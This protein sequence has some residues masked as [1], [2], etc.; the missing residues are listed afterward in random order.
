MK[1]GLYSAAVERALR[2]ALDAHDGQVRKGLDPVPYIVHPMHVAL[3]LTRLTDDPEVLIAAVLHDVVEDCV[4][5]DVERVA[6]EFGER[7]AS[8]VA[9]LTEDKSKSWAERKRGAIDGVEV[10]SVEALTVKA[11]DKLHN[12]RTLALDLE[13][14][15]DPAHVWRTFRG[16]REGTLRM[17]EELIAALAARLDPSIAEDL[18]A[19]LEACRGP[20]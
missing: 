2:V 13:R 20:G 11:C 1:G 14:A 4:E 6:R 15:T 10:L 5:W 16:G 8:I 9:E 17:D 19:A 18:R 12:L 7:V 3:M